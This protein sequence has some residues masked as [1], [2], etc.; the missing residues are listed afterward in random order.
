MDN[1]MILKLPKSLKTAYRDNAYDSQASYQ[2]TY[3]KV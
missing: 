1:Q 3:V 2:S